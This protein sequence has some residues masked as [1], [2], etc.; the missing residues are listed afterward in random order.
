MELEKLKEKKGKEIADLFKTTSRVDLTVGGASIFLSE[1]EEEIYRT[2]GGIFLIHGEPG[3][4]LITKKVPNTPREILV[5]VLN[6]KYVSPNKFGTYEH[7]KE[8]YK[9]LPQLSLEEALTM[10]DKY[11]QSPEPTLE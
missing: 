1:G 9:C 8:L 3:S 4:W 7:I 6:G 5:A 2:L 10:I 11:K